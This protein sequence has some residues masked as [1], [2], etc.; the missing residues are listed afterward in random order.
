MRLTKFSHACLRLEN[1]GGVLVI[2]PGVF[3]ELESLDGAD[4]VLITHEH[5][6]HL[7]LDKLA[8]AVARRPSIRIYTHSDVAPKLAGLEGTVEQVRPNQTFRA[9][10]FEVRA[11]G[12]SHAVIH[13]AIPVVANLGFLIDGRV[14]HPG[15]SFDVPQDASIDTVF[16]PISA[17]WL[18]TAESI[19]FLRAVAPRQAFALHDGLIN[20]NGLSIINRLLSMLGGTSYR[21]LTPGER[22]EV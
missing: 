20:D 11:Y 15:D 1:D 13:P 10:G 3:S 19:E 6:D 14:Y 5:V 21:R 18:K 2:D 17:P 22:I 7:D 9:A 8:D 12:G 16:V 4:A